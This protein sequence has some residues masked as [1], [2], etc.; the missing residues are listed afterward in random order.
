MVVA[1]N[2]FMLRT[3]WLSLAP[4]NVLMKYTK[5]PVSSMLITWREEDLTCPVSCSRTQLPDAS[6]SG[7]MTDRLMLMSFNVAD[8][9][10]V[11]NCITALVLWAWTSSSPDVPFIASIK[12]YFVMYNKTVFLNLG[13]FC[14]CTADS[15][16]NCL[17]NTPV[18]KVCFPLII[19]YLFVDCCALSLPGVDLPQFSMLRETGYFFHSLSVKQFLLLRGTSVTCLCLS[20]QCLLVS[21]ICLTQ[22]GMSAIH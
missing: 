13:V 16:D 10:I 6:V 9:N 20:F 1:P 8:V 5:S 22:H 14:C 7:L 11:D 18:L 21:T 15:D 17:T 19:L 2:K 3:M 4:M 12:Y